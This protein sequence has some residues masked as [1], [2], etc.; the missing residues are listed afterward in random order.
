[1]LWRNAG[2]PY[3]IGKFVGDVILLETGAGQIDRDAYR[4]ES[5]VGPRPEMS[6]GSGHHPVTKGDDQPAFLGQSDELAWREQAEARMLLTHQRLCAAHAPTAGIDFRLKMQAQLA[7]A[8]GSAQ[9]VFQ[10]QFGS[11]GAIHV[12]V[13]EATVRR[14]STLGGI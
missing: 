11:G 8:D 13:E 14:A 12:F 1:M 3:R 9:L 2:A 10:L 5:G 6:R 4:V 7:V